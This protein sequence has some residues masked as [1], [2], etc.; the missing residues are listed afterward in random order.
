MLQPKKSQRAAVVVPVIAKKPFLH[1]KGHS[2]QLKRKKAY[3][4]Q[5]KG[6]RLR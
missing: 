1:K 3:A 6:R 4:K 2:G 5:G